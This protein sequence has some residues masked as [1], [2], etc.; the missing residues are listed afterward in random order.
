M[1]Q[2]IALIIDPIDSLNP[3][4][5]SSVAM[6][7]AAIALGHV[8]W[9]LEMS[10]IRIEAGRSIGAAQ[11]LTLTLDAEPWYQ[12]GEITQRPLGQFDAILMR[13]DPPV[14]AAYLHCTQILDMAESEGARVFNEPNA[15][16]DLNEKLFALQFPQL[17]PEHVVTAQPEIIQNFAK[18]FETIILKPLDGMGGQGIVKTGHQQNGFAE[19]VKAITRDGQVLAMAQRYIPDIT[20]GD[21]RVLMVAGQPVSHVLARIPAKGDFRGNLAAGAHGEV[22]PLTKVERDI[23]DVIGPVLMAH[24][25]WFA[26]LDI[27]GDRL[28]EINVT[29]PTCIREIDAVAGTHIAIDLIKQITE[30]QQT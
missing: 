2:H 24:G 14:D 8:V 10:A 1:T 19:Q 12:L 6:M 21:K 28:T 3:E 16:R 30:Y 7:E 23:A 9:I 25:V 17:C 20:D 26:G 4:K 27:I 13:K 11:E 22:R 5:D 29:S 18:Q 15:L